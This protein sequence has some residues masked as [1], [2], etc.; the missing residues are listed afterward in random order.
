M[1][2]KDYVVLCISEED[3]YT[4]VVSAEN[5]MDA[6]RIVREAFPECYVEWVVEDGGEE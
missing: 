2:K 3:E 5:K 1:E 6:M 4:S